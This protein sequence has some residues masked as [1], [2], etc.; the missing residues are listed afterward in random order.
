MAGRTGRAQKGGKHD[1]HRG[2]L[3]Q[4]GVIMIMEET[5]S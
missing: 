1:K 4:L 2:M 5:T 3:I